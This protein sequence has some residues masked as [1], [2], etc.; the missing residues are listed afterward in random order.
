MIKVGEKERTLHFEECT[1]EDIQKYDLVDLW[2]RVRGCTDE[3]RRD[4]LALFA[5]GSLIGKTLEVDMAF[6]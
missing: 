2:V 3:L 5:V 6:T 1:N 4:Y